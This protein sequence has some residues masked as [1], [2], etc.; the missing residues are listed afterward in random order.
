MW[1][2]GKDSYLALSRARRRGL[3]IATLVNIYDQPTGRVRFHATR[4]ELIAAQAF[5]LGLRLHQHPTT[6][7]RYEDTFTQ[8]LR[9]LAESGHAG[10][11]F[12]NIHLADVRA[13]FEERVRAA[14]LE[15]LDPL[16][17]EPPAALLEEFVASGARAVVTCVE[18]AKLP[19]SWLGRTLDE[20]FPAAIARLPG[21]DPCGEY[22][23]YHT[24]V[25]AGP[26]FNRPVAWRPGP[27]HEEAGF[28]QLELLAR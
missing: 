18:T 27:I 26:L 11:V 23:E 21:V 15:H 24:F 5:A 16:W 2:G 13:W 20:E 1:S 4:H 10:V 14:G 6:A 22:G 17:G 12:G 7:D 9:R 28:A 19:A 8:A 25:Y 3:G